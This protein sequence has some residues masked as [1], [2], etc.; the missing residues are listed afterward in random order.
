VTTQAQRLAALALLHGAIHGPD[1]QIDVKIGRALG[2]RVSHDGWWNWQGYGDNGPVFD[3][4]GDAWCIRRDAR[5]DSP[6]N[7]ALPRF[8]FMPRQDAETILH[9]A[10]HD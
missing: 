8:T 9:E 6:C 7:E 2:W 3:P 1:R 5:P 4:P 10:T